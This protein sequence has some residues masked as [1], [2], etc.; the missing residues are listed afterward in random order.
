MRAG[1]SYAAATEK[2]LM[3]QDGVKVSLVSARY[4]GRSLAKMYKTNHGNQMTTSLV[5]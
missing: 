1:D 4:A 3:S 2:S 5:R